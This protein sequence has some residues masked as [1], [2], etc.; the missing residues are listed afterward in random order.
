[1][2]PVMLIAVAVLGVVVVGNLVRRPVIEH[3]SFAAPVYESV[4]ELTVEADL[5]VLGTVNRLTGRDINYGTADE[6]EQIPE[7]GIPVAFFEV[8]VSEFLKG[9][10]GGPLIVGTLD[11]DQIMSAESTPLEV[12]QDLLLFLSL[13]HPP[14]ID[15]YDSVY[16]TVGLDNGVFDIAGDQV[17]P[18]MPEVLSA[19]DTALDL[20]AIRQQV[21][22]PG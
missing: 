18:R 9:E 22:S 6:S 8:T 11:H 19:D 4:E 15:L 16:T 1:M 21:A 3:G 5:V 17:Q 13:E 2:W 10:I 7:Q 20:D 14:G 12:G